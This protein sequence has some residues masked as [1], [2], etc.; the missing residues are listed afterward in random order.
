M[1]LE[2][3]DDIARRLK[4]LAERQSRGIDD[5]LYDM[6]KLHDTALEVAKGRKYATAADL[7]RVAK[8][9]ALEL[10]ELRLENGDILQ[11]AN[12]DESSRQIL[13]EIYDEKFMKH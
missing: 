6:L 11:P 8:K 13:Q 1:M 4:S 2:I 3:S 7:G 12:T 5:V 10:E 9:A